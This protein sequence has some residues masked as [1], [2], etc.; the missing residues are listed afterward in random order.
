MRVSEFYKLGRKQ[1]SLPFLDVD[2]IDDAKLFINANAIKQLNSEFGDSCKVLIRDFFGEF[3]QAI[4]NGNHSRAKGLLSQLREPNE[5]HLGLSYGESKGRGLGPKKAI[6]LW[7][8]F[9]GSKAVASGLL[10]DLEDSVLLIEGISHDILSDIIT[11]II[12]FPLIKYTQEV[13]ETFGIP[14]S[15]DI[16]SGPIWNPT[17]KCWENQ[18]VKLPAPNDQKLILVPKSIVRIVGDYNV[19]EYYR[20]YILE[21]L[22]TEELQANSEL[23]HIIKSG[24]N[25]GDSKVYIKGLQE[26]YGTEPKRVAIEQ[27]LVYPELFEKYK[28]DKAAPTPALS[29]KQIADA[30]NV[31]MP[32]WDSLLANLAKLEPGKKNAYE[33]ENAISDLLITMFHPALVD[34]EIQTPINNGM[35][36]VDLTFTNY[37][38]TGF[39]DWLG[40]NYSAPF[41]QIECKNFGDE[42]GNP[43][44][45]QMIG[46]FSDNRGRFG[47]VV[48]RKVEDREKMLK[49][50]KA[51]LHD[52]KCHILVIDDEDLRLLVDEVKIVFPQEYNFTL[53]RDYFKKLVY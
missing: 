4:K 26:K 36:R 29:H 18:F 45:D 1:S 34:P 23:V 43:E 33:Y 32:D 5:T 22:R 20:H 2:I 41:I 7:R 48:C 53:L 25:E 8:S 47:I 49:R 40:R 14:L 35:K 28:N 24:K 50:C 13:C 31:A 51:A 12:R 9:K 3:T 39:F 52:Q 11:N 19:N 10:T 30:L 21:R 27:T 15:D 17:E 44:I 16:D 42:I 37:A 38:K 6:E 46:R